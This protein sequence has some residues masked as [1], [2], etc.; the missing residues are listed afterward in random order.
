MPQLLWELQ[1]RCIDADRS[2]RHKKKTERRRSAEGGAHKLNRRAGGNCS[3]F[4]TEMH[5]SFVSCVVVFSCVFLFVFFFSSFF[6]F[7]FF[8]FYPPLARRSEWTA[9]SSLVSDR[10]QRVRHRLSPRPISRAWTKARPPSIKP[11]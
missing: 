10:T 4:I 11:K 9:I 2:I 3:S 6:S 1:F 7:F 8:C 5:V